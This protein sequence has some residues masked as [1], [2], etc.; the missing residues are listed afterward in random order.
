MVEREVLLWLYG[1]TCGSTH[2]L[3]L[4]FEV[5]LVGQN[6]VIPMVFSFRNGGQNGRFYRGWV[7]ERVVELAVLAGNHGITGGSTND[8]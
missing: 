1:R 6:K 7:S 4:G 8:V 2:K 5:G 3:I